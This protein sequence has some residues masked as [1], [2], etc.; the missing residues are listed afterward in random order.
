MKKLLKEHS[1]ILV[2]ALLSASL[3]CAGISPLDPGGY[4]SVFTSYSANYN[5]R[6]AD[7]GCVGQAPKPVGTKTGRACTSGLLFGLLAF[8]DQSLQ[9]AA[10]DGGIT[11]VTSVDYSYTHFLGGDLRSYPEGGSSGY[12]EIGRWYYRAYPGLSARALY[13]RSCLIVHGE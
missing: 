8:G 5:C 2:A 9:A 7:S 13:L 1:L 4:G 6:T 12:A 11:R 3:A 10:A